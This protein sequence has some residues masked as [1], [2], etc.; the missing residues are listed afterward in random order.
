MKKNKQFLGR[1]LL[2]VLL[3]AFSSC[4]SRQQEVFPEY[5]RTQYAGGYLRDSI[6]VHDSVLVREKADTVFI[7]RTHTLY[8]DRQRTDTLWLHDTIVNTQEVVVARNT[9]KGSP[10]SAVAFLLLLLVLLWK[11]G[12]LSLAYHLFGKIIK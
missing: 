2:F 11:S 5:I 6:F 7:V 3:A 12:I 1:L 4:R 9:D 10:W 8:R